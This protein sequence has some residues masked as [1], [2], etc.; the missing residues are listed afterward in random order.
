M[1]LIGTLPQHAVIIGIDTSERS[2]QREACIALTRRTRGVLDNISVTNNKYNMRRFK[3]TGEVVV[4][5]YQVMLTGLA[6]YGI[7]RVAIGVI[8]GEFANV[9]FGMMG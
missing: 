2:E 4:V 8:M 6:V 1:E 5:S 3:N 7:I 9:S